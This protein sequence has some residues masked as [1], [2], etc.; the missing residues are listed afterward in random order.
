MYMSSILIS[1]DHVNNQ[2]FLVHIIR[3]TSRTTTK[4]KMEAFVTIVNSWKSLTF[5][6]KTPI[7]AVAAA[8]NLS[9]IMPLFHFYTP[10][11]CWNAS[12][13]MIS[14]G[15]EWGISQVWIN[16][17]MNGSNKRLYTSYLT[18]PYWSLTRSKD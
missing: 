4:S 6:I 13:L 17:L 15:I 1:E 9:L 2:T 12:F 16:S 18:L 5:D 10:W 7:L 11:N 8:L 14:K 3:S